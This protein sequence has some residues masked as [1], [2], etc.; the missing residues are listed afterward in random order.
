MAEQLDAAVY[1]AHPYLSWEHGLN[2]NT[3]WLFGRCF[4]NITDE[5]VKDVM[6]KLNNRPRKSLNYNTPQTVFFGNNVLGVAWLV[7]LCFGVESA[8]YKLFEYVW[9]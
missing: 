7:E 8:L 1:F 5:Q 4:K 2:E 3:N 6:I 9:N